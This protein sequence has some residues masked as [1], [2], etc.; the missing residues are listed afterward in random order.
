MTDILTDIEILE[1]ALIALEEGASDERRSAI[2][3]LEQMLGRK[4][5]I[6]E[7]FETQEETA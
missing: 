7:E 2:W 4:M 1:N 6:V 5:R 3:S